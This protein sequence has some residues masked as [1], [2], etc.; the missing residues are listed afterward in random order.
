MNDN[1][2]YIP[3]KFLAMIKSQYTEFY[4]KETAIELVFV[5]F[6]DR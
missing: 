4:L 5:I 6:I 3:S 1:E 2:W